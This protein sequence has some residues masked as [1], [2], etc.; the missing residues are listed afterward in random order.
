VNGRTV[1]KD[2]AK[3][4]AATLVFFLTIEA[5]LRTIYFARNSLADYVPLPYSIEDEYGPTPPWLDGLRI[6]ERDETFI[7]KS[8]PSLKRKYVDL[9]SPVPNEQMRRE[10]LR[11]FIPRL[12]DYLKNN[13]T[14]EISLNSQGFRDEEF[15]AGKS[16][17]ALRIV[18]LGDSWT[19]GANVG[20]DQTYPQRLKA[21]LRQ[22]YPK[23]NL[24]IFNLGVLGY[25]SYQGLELL[26]RTAITMEPDVVIIGY[27]WNDASQAGFHD[28]DMPAFKTTR[29]EKLE[30]WLSAH[31]E[32]YK[33]LR[34]LLSVMTYRPTS[35]SDKLKKETANAQSA[36]EPADYAKL[37]PWIRVPLKEYENNISEMIELARNRGAAVILLYNVSDELPQ[38]R[39]Y[40]IALDKISRTK[41]VPL[42]DSSALVAN[43]RKNIE[44][45]MESKLGLQPRREL[46]PPEN[47]ETQVVF[48][49][50]AENYPV[51][52]TIY[53]AGNHPQLGDVT[54]NKIAMYDDGTHGDQRAGDRVWSYSASFTPGTKLFYVYT[55]SGAEGRWEG[56]DLPAIRS[57][58]VEKEST[59]KSY[60]PIESFG[61]LY[62]HADNWHTDAA[63][64]ELIAEA[65]FDILR[66]DQKVAD[67]LRHVHEAR[68]RELS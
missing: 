51:P 10:L 2:L 32:S 38:Y 44:Q 1:F 5:L 62:M 65:L 35:L 16:P 29:T 42:V 24:E 55:N 22:E 49:V 34:Y 36:G 7:W 45:D 50:Y 39:R 8:R 15:P 64:Y 11:Q 47:G 21:L 12:P 13:P 19:F 60:R 30:R 6:L 58:T 68:S 48:R 3:V 27:A 66:K 4:L 37:E 17:G 25:S 18:C 31:S 54:P 53:I 40:R 33:L 52:R 57:F 26:R 41:N 9:F 43:A 14:W 67:Y 63:G 20:Q 56:L 28:S 23:T 59:G 61:E 46:R